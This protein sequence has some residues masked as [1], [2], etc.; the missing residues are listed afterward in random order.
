PR[1]RPALPLRALLL[2]RFRVPKDAR[3][4][5]RVVGLAETGLLGVG[6]PVP[7]SGCQAELGAGPRRRLEDQVRVLPGAVER[8]P[9]RVLAAVNRGPTPSCPSVT[10]TSARGSATIVITTSTRPARSAGLAAATTPAAASGSALAGS[11]FQT[12]S[13]WPASASRRAIRLPIAPSPTTPTV[14]IAYAARSTPSS[15]RQF[16][17][18]ARSAAAASPP[19]RARGSAA[20][21]PAP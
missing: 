8:E 10:S 19:R 21:A 14:A 4:H 16:A 17:S 6:Q 3:E 2:G 13:S 5:S 18:S 15:S 11:R 20:S 9:R 7:R 12:T 1:D